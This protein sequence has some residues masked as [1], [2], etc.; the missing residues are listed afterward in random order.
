MLRVGVL[1][2]PVFMCMDND[3]PID[4]MSMFVLFRLYFKL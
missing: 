1:V 3:L 2:K 4:R